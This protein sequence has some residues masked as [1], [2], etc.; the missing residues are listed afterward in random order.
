MDI[1]QSLYSNL[2]DEDKADV[3]KELLHACVDEI[4]G[5]PGP[6]Y[7]KFMNR[8]NWSKEAY[9]DIYKLIIML[10]RNPACLYLVEEKMP[11]EYHDLP[12]SI[13]KDILNCLKVRQE[14]LTHALLMEHSKQ[15]LLTLVDFDWRLK[16]VM[17]TSKMASLREPLLQLDFI[18]EEKGTRCIID[19][20]MNKDELDTLITTMETIIQ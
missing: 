14:Q 6:S 12:E 19:V 11:P 18:V 2:I 4:C 7:H 3:L 20:E 13:Q 9:E 10:L 16:L 1:I 8:M 17:G 15:K 5:H